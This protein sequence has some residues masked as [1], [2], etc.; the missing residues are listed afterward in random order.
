MQTLY[1]AIKP[2]ATHELA[3]DAPHTLY[4]EEVGN[5]DG[6][7]IIVLHAGPG[8]GGDPYLR[9]YFDPEQYR[10][11]LFDQRGTGRSTP[12]ADIKSNTTDDL[13]EDID[14]IRDYLGLSR[15]ILSGGGWGSTLALLYAERYPIHVSGLLL[16]RIFLA[17]KKDIDW[18]Y[19]QGANLIYPDYWKDFT[20]MIPSE[21]KHNIP[22]FYAKQ[23]QSDNEIAR[24]SAAKAWGNWQARCASIQPHQNV[25]DYY[26]DPHFA[27]ALATIESHY[28]TN[29]Y[30]IEENQI[31]NDICKIRQIPCYI[32]HGRYDMVCPFASA[33][34]LHQALPSS[35]L[36]IIRDAGHSDREAGMIDALIIA[37]KDLVRHDLDVS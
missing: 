20:H 32:I 16:Q 23:L 31:L 4:F 21:E 35:Q 11:I 14:A 7:P 24:M 6:V 33:F 5:P 30:F 2:Y 36:S 18:F 17:R 3:V 22:A 1:P 15:F 25:I 28:V 27:L 34:D 10:I 13:I 19:K 37:S 12:H 8:G 29:H 26:S 9:R